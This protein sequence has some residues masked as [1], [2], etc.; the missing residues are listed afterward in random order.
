MGCFENAANPPSHTAGRGAPSNGDMGEMEG[1]FPKRNLPD[2]PLSVPAGHSDE[3][4]PPDQFH[5]DKSQL[6]NSFY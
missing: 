5:F 6:P 1:G 2:R 3:I 4:Q